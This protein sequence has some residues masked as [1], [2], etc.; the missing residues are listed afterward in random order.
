[1]QSLSKR[2]FKILKKFFNYVRNI[3]NL[4]VRYPFVKYGS[5]VHIQWN[6]EFFSPNNRVSIGNHVG[7]NSGTVIIS[8]LVVGNY[9]LI[10]PRCG[11][12]NRGEHTYD[13]CGQPIY[14]GPRAR[15][16]VIIIKDDVWIGYGSTILGGVTIGE[17][18][19]VAAGS[20]VINDVPEYTIVAGNPAKLIKMRFNKDE[21]IAHKEML[22]K[23]YEKK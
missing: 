12:I 17:G 18:S 2:A 19:I 1:M 23:R 22:R 5:D 10:A 14:Y 16:E 8:D 3:L 9:V 20:I 13:V 4:N 11:F 7:I 21:I 15:S 6:V